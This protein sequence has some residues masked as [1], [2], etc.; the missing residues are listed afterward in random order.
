M[1]LYNCPLGL[2][3]VEIWSRSYNKSNTGAYAYLF[4]HFVN[5]TFCW[6]EDIKQY[7][8]ALGFLI[9]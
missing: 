1:Q 3:Q 4:M 7:T 6:L 2:K 5:V 8:P 9:E